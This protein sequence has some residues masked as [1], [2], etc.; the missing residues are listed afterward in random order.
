MGADGSSADTF[1]QHHQDLAESHRLPYTVRLPPR[2]KG[3]SASIPVQ[4]HVPAESHSMVSPAETPRR[5]NG[6]TL[7]P[8]AQPYQPQHGSGASY[9]AFPARET[10]RSDR[11]PPAQL[12]GDGPSSEAEIRCRFPLH[13]TRA[14]PTK[15]ERRKLANK[16][17]A[18]AE[19]E[20]ARV[21]MA[22]SEAGA[23]RTDMA[24]SEA[25]GDHVASSPV[26]EE[27]GKEDVEDKASNAGCGVASW[28]PD[29]Q[30]L[31]VCR[32][33]V[34]QA[35]ARR[36]AVV[37]QFEPGDVYVCEDPNCT[38][39]ICAKMGIQAAARRNAVVEQSEPGDVYVCEDPNCTVAICAKMRMPRVD[40][41]ELKV[42][43][44][45]VSPP[46]P[47]PIEAKR[48]VASHSRARAAARR[49]FSAAIRSL[50][51]VQE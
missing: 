3:S 47:H 30:W 12:G 17:K 48:S 6:S 49:L 20:A 15:R 22:M 18:E 36:N 33:P 42:K 13:G 29:S 50:T 24:L 39:A 28:P 14:P 44:D 23:V 10:V 45:R 37:E 1:A 34:Y 25:G 8:V 31:A 16:I 43:A 40:S 51:P 4:Q 11:A 7:S 21:A 5:R 46:P 35:G 32:S 41:F 27:G 9:K 19:A 38:V 2:E 26:P